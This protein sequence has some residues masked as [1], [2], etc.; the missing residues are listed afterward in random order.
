AFY[1]QSFANPF[2][3]ADVDVDRISSHMTPGSHHL[4]LNEVMSATP[5][6]LAPCSGLIPP[7]GPYASQQPDD[8]LTYPAGVAALV[9]AKAGFMLQVHYLNTS[10]AS[11]QPSVTVSLHRPDVPA[12]A[13]AEMLT[14]INFDIHVAPHA[15]GNA[16]STTDLPKA[17]H[18]LRVGGH[19]HRWGTRF[20]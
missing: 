8:A 15:K 3:A 6:P 2:G 4:L 10:G 1:C 17:V 13:H 19:M 20:T 5:A 18:L 14:A 12:T 7:T 16:T 9:G 11:L